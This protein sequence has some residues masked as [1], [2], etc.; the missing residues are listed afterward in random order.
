[1]APSPPSRSVPRMIDVFVLL[2]G[3]Y[4]TSNGWSSISKSEKGRGGALVIG[5]LV[6]C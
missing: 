6:G 3:C 5:E 1:M 2:M 4:N